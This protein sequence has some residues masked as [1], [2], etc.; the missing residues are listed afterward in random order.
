MHAGL[1]KANGTG[2]LQGS[3][4]AVR[5]R[6]RWLRIPAAAALAVT[7]S[8]LALLVAC[9]LDEVRVLSPCSSST[10]A[11]RHVNPLQIMTLCMDTQDMGKIRG[12]EGSKLLCSQARVSSF[13]VKMGTG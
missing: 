9:D 6:R 12:L 1:G 11:T 10:R 3:V 2:T 13:W 7:G 5:S 8:G 4:A